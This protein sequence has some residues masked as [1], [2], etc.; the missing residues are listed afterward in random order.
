MKYKYNYVIYHKGCIDGFTGFFILHTTKNISS[1]AKIYPDVPSAKTPPNNIEDKDVIIIDVAYKYDVLKEIMRVA[2][3]VTFID[4]H[5]SIK[6]DVQKIIKELNSKKNIVIYDEEKSGA[7][8]TWEYFYPKTKMPYF[9]RFVEDNDIGRWAL[10]YCKEFIIALETKFKLDNTSENLK[11]WK[12]LFDKKTIKYLISKGKVYM[13]YRNHLLDINSHRFSLEYF[14]SN[15]LY[16]DFS[17]EFMKPGQYKVALYCGS[18]CPS[19]SDVGKRIVETVDCDFA[20]MWVY[21]MDKKE[22]VLSFRS[23][24]TDVTPF[25][26]IFGG[27]GHKLASACSFP[28]TKYNIKDLFFTN[29]LPRAYKK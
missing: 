27:G 18:G 5:V 2:K 28:D 3:S 10:K 8:L 14:P 7:S 13:E 22:Y 1:K 24:S 19:G 26:R 21:N 17:T 4:H 16:N 23:A 29:S 6:D 25:A 9:V 20:I 15:Q 12:L 11:K